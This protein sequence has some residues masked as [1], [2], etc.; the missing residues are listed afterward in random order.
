MSGLNQ[1]FYAY[2]MGNTRLRKTTRNIF[3]QFAYQLLTLTLGVILPRYI[4]KV[5]GSDVNGLTSTIKHVL[6][7]VT[8]VQAGL[9]T[10]ATYLLYK[11]LE[12]KDRIKIASLLYSIKKWYRVIAIIVACLGLAASIILSFAVNGEIA[13]KYIFIASFITCIDSALSIYFTATCNVFLNAKQDRYINSIVLLITGTLSYAIQI[14]I[15]LVKPHFLFLY[16]NNFLICVLNIIILS[17]VFKKQYS[18]YDLN[19]EEKKE[20]KKVPVPGVTFAAINEASHAAVYGIMTVAVSVMSD[21]KAASVLSV[22]MM[23]INLISTVSNVFYTSFVSSYGSMVAE[24]DM[25]KINT[26]FQIFQFSFFLLTTFLFMCTSYL[27]IPFIRIYTRDATDANYINELLAILLIVYG[28]FYAYRI[29][30][31]NTISVIGKFKE[32]YLQPLI[33]AIIAIGLMF[34]LTIINYSLVVV[35]PIFFYVVNTFYQHF[36][37]KKNF[38]GFDNNHFWRH[39]LVSILCVSLAIVAY[40][41]YPITP[42]SFLRWALCGCVV[43]VISLIVLFV[44][45]VLI[46]RKSFLLSFNYFKN[47]LFKK[48]QKVSKED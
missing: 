31:N 14:V 25:N 4:I 26:V 17:I 5:Y 6:T 16:F 28:L 27:L 33:C 7:L 29:P 39:F 37:I 1:L 43:A 13:A 45:I 8:I 47:R 36:F 22:Y 18:P 20:I 11:P 30:Y 42:S 40:F 46:D 19:P 23:V 32:T 44:A 12:E 15:L 21:L 24:G 10:S 41:I 2:K 9:A 35:G 48:K 38:E 3:W 34:G